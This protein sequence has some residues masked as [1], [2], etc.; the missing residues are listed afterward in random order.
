MISDLRKRLVREEAGFTLTE[1]LVTMMIML[2]VLFALF[3]IF[4]MSIR[5]FSF[6]NDKIEATEQARLGMEKMTREIRATYPV[7]KISGKQHVF[8]TAGTSATA[9]RPGPSSITFG[10]DLPDGA[11]PPNRMVDTAEEITYELRSSSNLGNACPTTGTDGICTLVRRKGSTASFQP[12]IEYVVPNGLT[13]EYLTNSMGAT[14]STGNG[15]DIGVVRVTLRVAVDRGIQ[16]Q[17][18]RQTLTTDVDLKNR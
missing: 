5:V 10:N 9:T 8:F 13:F 6:G 14:D 1:V 4:D 3:S 18:V 2:I 15:T 16:E 11:T 7:D 12:V 17:P